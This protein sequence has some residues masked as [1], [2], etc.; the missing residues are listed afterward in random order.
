MRASNIMIVTCESLAIGYGQTPLV[1]NLS[2]SVKQGEICAVI[3]HNGAGKSTL[4]KSL[5]GLHEPLSGSISWQDE[6]PPKRAYLGQRTQFDGQFPVRVRDLVA[7]GA[8]HGLGFWAHIDSAK[9]ALVQKALEQTNLEHMADRPLFECSSGQLQRCFFARAIVQ[10][11]P[12]ILL[13]EP[14]TAIDQSTQS[15]LIEIIKNWRAEGRGLFIVLHDLSVV[16]GLCDKVLL[17]GG[18]QALFGET[19]LVLRPQTLIDYGYLSK[20]QAE[21][22]SAYVERAS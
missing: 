18:G 16:K 22:L 1:E 5:L 8:W 10:D 4:I 21:W 7:M 19:P 20:T 2:F 13:D 12:F 15:N 11:A 17:M 6:T 9:Q 14:F 3:G